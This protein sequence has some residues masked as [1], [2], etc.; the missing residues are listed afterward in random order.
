MGIRVDQKAINNLFPGRMFIM[1]PEINSLGIVKI[2]QRL[3][4]LVR[5]LPIGH[6]SGE[7]TIIA[8]T[9]QSHAP[10]D[11]TEYLLRLAA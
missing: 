3:I 1:S 2:G 9:G 8:D 10:Y 4:G 11:Y 7:G 6:L 5:R